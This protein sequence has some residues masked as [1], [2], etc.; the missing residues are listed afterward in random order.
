MKHRLIMLYCWAIRSFMFF[1]PDLPLI[2]RFRGWLYGLGMKKIGR[3]FQVAHNVI[4]NSIENLEVGNNVYI[5]QYGII[6]AIGNVIL[7]D[8]IIIGPNCL[9]S[10]SN[11]SF[12]NDSYWNGK[13]ICKEIHIGAG[14]WIA[15]HCVILAGSVLPPYSLLAAGATLTNVFMEDGIYGGTPAKLIRSGQLKS[16]NYE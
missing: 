7:D 10:S 5:G 6:Y 3:N 1:L 11:H 12:K 16:N 8:N 13:R 14:C 4:L 9:I 2:M 15:G